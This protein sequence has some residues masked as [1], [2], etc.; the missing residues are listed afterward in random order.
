MSNPSTCLL[1]PVGA[2]DMDDQH[3]CYR[4]R[5]INFELAFT[6][7]GEIQENHLNG[8]PVV[9]LGNLLRADPECSFCALLESVKY[10]GDASEGFLECDT[11]KHHLRAFCGSDSILFT[12]L[13]GDCSTKFPLVKNIVAHLEQAVIMPLDPT[14]G[15]TN[16]VLTGQGC[17]V[18]PYQINY[19]LLSTWLSACKHH[20]KARCSQEGNLPISLKLIDCNTR[21]IVSMQWGWEYWALSYVWGKPSSPS[22]SDSQEPI[23][24]LPS[25]LPPTIEDAITVVRNLGG[26]YLWVDKYCIDQNSPN[27]KHEQI[28]QMDSIYA[29]AHVTIIAAGSQ[30]SHSTLPGVSTISR[31]PQPHA[32]SRGRGFVSTLPDLKAALVGSPWMSRGWTFQEGLLSRRCLIFTDHQ[33]YFMC[34]QDSRRESIKTNDSFLPEEEV[35]LTKLRDPDF[36]TPPETRDPN[37]FNT[38]IPLELDFGMYL[39]QY[40]AISLS[41]SSDAINAFR[42]I[43]VRAGWTSYWGIPFFIDKDTESLT[44]GITLGFAAGLSWEPLQSSALPIRSAVERRSQFPSWSWAGWKGSV[45][46][47]HFKTRTLSRSHSITGHWWPRESYSRLFPSPEVWVIEEQEPVRLEHYFNK[48]N[49]ARMLPENSPQIIIA[50]TVIRAPI[51]L[52][53]NDQY[54]RPPGHYLRIGE[55]LSIA[56]ILL[57]SEPSIEDIEHPLTISGQYN[58]IVLF[59][60]ALGFLDLDEDCADIFVMLVQPCGENICERLGSIWITQGE[61]DKLDKS[62]QKVTIC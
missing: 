10:K 35:Y 50:S 19:E 1:S 36:L 31:Q 45:R 27:E 8:V 9:D 21:R 48:F 34:G 3:L 32:Y 25:C 61:F 5:A 12:V 28:S 42:G 15:P 24:S 18:H 20:H 47:C 46:Y 49:Q 22:E 2:K 55:K 7:L 39:A 13:P 11:T 56:P 59:Q 52:K 57:C 6:L 40:S 38:N 17:M 53:D 54:C 30:I 60:R 62:R 41:Y 14:L 51:V 44:K 29:N 37:Y 23:H 58:G 43:L 16:K 26:R 4:C 33:V